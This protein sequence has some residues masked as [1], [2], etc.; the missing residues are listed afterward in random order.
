MDHHDGFRLLAHASLRAQAL[1]GLCAAAL[2]TTTFQE[3]HPRLL[4]KGAAVLTQP[5]VA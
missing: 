2:F 1:G 4:H 3:Q 5:A